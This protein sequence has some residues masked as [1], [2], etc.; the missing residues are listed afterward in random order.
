MRVLTSERNM[1]SEPEE[2]K[3]YSLRQ[4]G[5]DFNVIGKINKCLAAIRNIL[6]K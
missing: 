4:F 6:E 3:T 2:R 1:R 5:D